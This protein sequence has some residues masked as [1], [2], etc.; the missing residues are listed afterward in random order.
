M[1]FIMWFLTGLLV[2]I[3]VAVRGI[4]AIVVCF[5]MSSTLNYFQP[6]KRR[7]ISFSFSRKYVFSAVL[8]K[9]TLWFSFFFFLCSRSYF[10]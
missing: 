3:P 10:G 8:V 9:L 6:H 2:F 4:V 1:L 5:V 7:V